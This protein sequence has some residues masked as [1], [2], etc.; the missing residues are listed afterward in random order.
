M[1]YKALGLIA[2][3][4]LVLDYIW[5]SQVFGGIFGEMVE[6]IQAKPM[7]VR[8]E[9]AAIVYL[10]MVLGLYIFVFTRVVSVKEAVMYGA[11]FGLV[12]FG[13][14]DFTNTA[15][16]T[17]YDYTIASID[18]MWGTVLNAAVAGLSVYLLK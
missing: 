16:F 14:F 12:T 5:L 3:L 6:S 18:V 9:P 4:V 13:I 17:D 7:L 11:L 1:N 8:L 15:L 2:I 10:L